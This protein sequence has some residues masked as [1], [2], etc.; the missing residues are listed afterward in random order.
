MNRSFFYLILFFAGALM[1][2]S[3]KQKTLDMTILT[4]TMY[5]DAVFEG[6]HVED[7]WQVTIVQDSQKKGVELEYSAFL[8]DYLRVVKEGSTLDISFS[9]RLNL[10]VNTVKNATVYVSSLDKLALSEASSIELQGSFVSDSLS[11][12]M[13]EASTL[14]GGCY[15]GKLNMELHEA[16]VVA[17]FVAE[18][19]TCHLILEEGS[20]FK[21]TLTAS[22]LLDVEISDASRMTTYGG[23]TPFAKVTMEEAGFLNMTQTVTQEMHI[24]M[25]SASEASVNV[26]NRIDGSLQDASKLFLIGNPITNL[27]CDDTSTLSPL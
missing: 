11:V 25:R 5:E 19:A 4:T 18:G 13:E 16:S 7:A 2:P 8:E 21:G 6:I 26:I 23:N 27:N 10:P 15:S 12:E 14:R 22:D 20:V 17:D 1:M 24:D 3:C 9:Q